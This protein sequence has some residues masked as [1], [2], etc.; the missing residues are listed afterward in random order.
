MIRPITVSDLAWVVGL[1]MQRYGNH[2]D[3]GGGLEALTQAMRLK[4]AIAWR[5]DHGF[6]IGNI[7]TTLW[8][9]KFPTLHCLAI[10][11]EE[12]HHWEAIELLR[13]SIEW[14][15]KRGCRRWLL[16]SDTDHRIDALAFRVGAQRAAV[17]EVNFAEGE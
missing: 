3:A 13:E 10:C 17:Y 14:A 4:S 11:T 16:N 5:T 1:G 8:A 15:R 7:V 9:P 6:L 2:Y 12:G